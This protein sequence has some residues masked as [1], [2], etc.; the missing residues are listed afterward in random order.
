MYVF[1]RMY[2]YNAMVIKFQFYYAD[3]I[4]KITNKY[5]LINTYL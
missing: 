5:I 4:E 3:N 1:I 2:K